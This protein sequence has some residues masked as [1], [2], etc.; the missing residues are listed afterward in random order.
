MERT[1][2]VFMGTSV[3][4]GKAEML[5]VTTGKRTEL[6]QLA[7]H[8]KASGPA[9]AL[10]RGAQSFGFLIM[11]LTTLLALFVLSVHLTL[12]R[13]FIDSLLFALALAV[14]LTPELLPMVVAVTL[15]RGA[16]RLA[17]GKVIVKRLAAIHDLGAM[18]VLCTDK[19][20]TLTEARI[21]F[22]R[23]VSGNGEE[24]AEVLQLAHLNS[25]NAHGFE[26][27][28]DAALRAAPAEESDWNGVDEA[29][30][31]F[32]RRRVS[33]LLARGS[34][35][36]IVTKGAVEETLAVCTAIG[37]PQGAVRPMAAA[38]REAV[39]QRAAAIGENGE[40]ALAV[41][42]KRAPEEARLC[43]A[44]DEHDLVFAG[45]VTFTDPPK[46][47]AGASIGELAAL[48]VAVKILTG[49]N[50]AVTRHVCRE[51]GLQIT[52]VLE[53]RDIDRLDEAGLAAAVQRANVFCRLTPVQKNRIILSLRRRR[54]VV[55][56]LGDGVNDAPSLHDADVGLS[57]D[58]AV[59]VAREA[60]GIILLAPDLSILARGVR[61]G[62][63]TFSNIMKY[64][65]MAVSSN[66]G[67]MLSM[68]G[69]ALFLPFLPMTAIQIL[70][71]NL[72]Y[73]VSE[74][75]IPLD[76]VDPI[77][78]ARPRTWNMQRVTRFMLIMGPVS[79]V[80]D[81]LTFGLLLFVFKADATTFQSAWFTES[82]AS[83]SLVIFIIR[84]TQAPW[85]SRPHPWLAASAGGAAALA[86]LFPSTPIGAL[87]GLHALP[88][89][90]A[91]AIA[92]LV[93]A[94]LVSAEAAKRFYLSWERRRAA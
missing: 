34:E 2:R 13:P 78:V 31:D 22:S 30:F 65:M 62:R 93:I 85:R 71:N 82:L 58:G 73:D 16:L 49:D 5:V 1:N 67:N 88:L 89:P 94:Y 54:E 35:R 76:Q 55:G 80:F 46:R 27:P 56:Y 59:D 29:P 3:V 7:R 44:K 68:A 43:S 39:R 26:S 11:R 47:S 75:T 37:A 57:V 38:D 32:D 52:D 74:T 70:L 17:E 9:S 41:A 81:F 53:G 87:F 90:L 79:S 42:W 24:D 84:T 18:T 12:G 91:G 10:D 66:F 51:I 69:A 61:E 15:S 23:A 20:G 92:G 21:R 50:A 48:N 77:D 83:Q 36:M 6:G 45:F 40:R 60:S 8:L 86:F 63:R 19:T 28:L 72:I 14:G 64:V 4:S 25:A 33:V